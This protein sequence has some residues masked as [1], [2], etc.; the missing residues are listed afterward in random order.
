[1]DNRTILRMATLNGAAALGW[2]DSIGSLEPGKQADWTAVRLPPDPA[3]DPLEAILT[4]DAQV[5]R[6]AIAGKVIFDSPD[7]QD[8]A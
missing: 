1:V 2:A 3:A 7:Q 4:T 6:T 8:G 5:I